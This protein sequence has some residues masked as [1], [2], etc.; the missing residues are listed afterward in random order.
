MLVCL[1]A[2]LLV[3]L[4]RDS[5]NVVDSL[6]P[7]LELCHDQT[8]TVFSSKNN[9]KDISSN[10]STSVEEGCHG[11]NCMPPAQNSEVEALAPR[12]IVFGDKTLKEVFKIKRGHKG[13]APIQQE[14]NT[15]SA[16]NVEE[17]TCKDTMRRHGLQAR[18]RNVTR[19]QPCWLLDL[20]TPASRTVKKQ[21]FLIEATQFEV[22]CYG[23]PSI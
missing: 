7:A 22:F 11:L 1:Q 5:S 21:I 15:R 17:R 14:E 3:K 12:G 2:A 13:G 20:G 19:N 16:G 8:S 4:L 10:S 9:F 6:E 18:R 23:N